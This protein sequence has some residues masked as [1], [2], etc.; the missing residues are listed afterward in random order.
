MNSFIR[1]FSEITKNDVPLVGG[2]GANLGEMTCAG[3]PVPPGFCVVADAYREFTAHAQE[4]IARILNETRM[5]DADDVENK[6]AQLRE[7]LIMQP[8]PIEIA[9]QVRAAYLELAREIEGREGGEG[10]EGGEGAEGIGDTR[11]AIG[12]RQSAMRDSR[13]RVA[14]RSSAT[15]EDLPD[16]S[17][18]GQ[19]DTYLNVQGEDA[20]LEHVK[21][22]W[23]SLWTARAVMYRHKQGY[24]HDQVALAVVVQAMIESEVAGILFTANPVNQNRAEMVLN[25]SW[26]LGEAIV[27]GLVTPDTW[28]VQKDGGI[29]E[30]DIA[31]KD[32]AIEYAPGGGTHEVG[33]ADEKRDAP[34]LDDAQLQA[35]A[36]LGVQVETHY[37]RPMDIEWAYARGKFYMLQA[38]PITTLATESSPVT[39]HPDVSSR[40]PRN[41]STMRDDASPSPTQ[42]PISNLQSLPGEYNRSMFIEIFPDPLSPAFLSVIAPLFHSMLDFT[43][44]TLGFTPPR[45][46][47]AIGV[48]YNQPYFHREYIEAA[49]APLSPQVRAALVT[50]IVN[51]FGKH[52]RKLPTEA[53]PAFLGMVA[54]LL[55]FMT[56]FP[57]QLPGLIAAYRVEIDQ[58]NALPIRDLSDHEILARIRDMCYDHASKLL[59]YDFLMIALIGITYQ[60]LGSVLERYYGDDTEQI[61]AKL[62]SGVTGNVTMETNKKIWDLAQSAKQSASVR[63]ILRINSPLPLGEGLGVRSDVREKLQADGDGRIFLAE[64][65]AFLEQ[66]GHREIRMDILYPTWSEDPLPVLQF[67]R[68]Y[69]DVDEQASPRRQ[70][71]RLVQEREQLA[72]EVSVHVQRDVAGRFAIAPLFQ[73]VLKNTQAHTR[74]RDTMHFEL[75]R[76]FPPLRRCLLELGARWQSQGWLDETDDIFYLTLEE[77]QELAASPHA[78]REVIQ[79]RRAEFQE[80]LERTPPPIVRDGVGVEIVRTA[81]GE[82]VD[83][84]LRGIAGSPGVATGIVRV[85]RG[86]REFEKLQRGEI[87][88]A[89]LTNPVWTPLFAIAG[90]IVTQ[91]GGILSHGAIVAREYGIPAV[92]AVPDATNLLHDGQAV[93]VDGNRGIVILET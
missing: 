21:R 24:A 78:R 77:M 70:E 11:Y 34:S 60:M 38:R 3:L 8:M 83:G 75:T 55:R 22:C 33:V 71:A 92:M 61:R 47:P 44:E 43:F 80:N 88:V 12:D 53:S 79:T 48:F 40:T 50:Q 23:A 69:L 14:V 5:D 20:L 4:T 31:T 18:A 10:G 56:G 67:I 89:P 36:A 49:F 1:A 37:A 54:R 32:L 39:R 57:K 85:V 51:P 26:G 81:S 28:I 42:S 16:A 90:G 25:A 82:H 93:T 19:Q 86:P 6:T 7:F 2:K 41:L 45:D 91:V 68:G 58:L 84:Q 17:F 35:L 63:E 74:E 76:L 27:A 65:D 9:E 46:I 15:A 62:I 72:Q 30:R 52:E 87:L 64:L 73:W 59:N 13:I 29:L 66:Y